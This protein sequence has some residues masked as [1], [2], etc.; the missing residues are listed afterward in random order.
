[1]NVKW[2]ASQIYVKSWW[3]IVDCV[4]DSRRHPKK[5]HTKYSHM[6]LLHNGDASKSESKMN[7]SQVWTVCEAHDKGR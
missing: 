6:M 4:V 3:R 7:E 2:K 1:M 5:M